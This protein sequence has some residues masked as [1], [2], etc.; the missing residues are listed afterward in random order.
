MSSNNA[1]P[2]DT[3]QRCSL[4]RNKEHRASQTLPDYTLTVLIEASEISV[5]KLSHAADFSPPQPYSTPTPPANATIN[6]ATR[7][8]E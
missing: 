5:Y 1:F 3:K 6:P 4:R 7:D 2:R 8:R